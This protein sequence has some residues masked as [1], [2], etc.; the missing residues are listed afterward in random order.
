MTDRIH[1]DPITYFICD[2]QTITR[3]C[4]EH[5]QSFHVVMLRRV[6]DDRFSGTCNRNEGGGGGKWIWRWK[7]KNVRKCGELVRVGPT[8]LLG[9]LET[10]EFLHP[11]PPLD[12]W[13]RLLCRLHA[14]HIWYITH[15]QINKSFKFYLFDYSFISEYHFWN[16]ISAWELSNAVSRI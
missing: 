12:T 9:V 15:I 4:I 3:K 2:L 7:G 8:I 16:I 10:G 5:R 13:Q 14:T 1:Y 11:M 6:S